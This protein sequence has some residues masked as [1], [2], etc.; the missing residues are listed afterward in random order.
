MNY[1]YAI[2]LKGRVM[3]FS[4]KNIIIRVARLYAKPHYLRVW[5]QDYLRDEITMQDIY[6]HHLVRFNTM[7]KR[8][9]YF[10]TNNEKFIP[11]DI[12]SKNARPNYQKY[13]KV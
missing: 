10:N 7:K 9:Q 1:C 13:W 4:H 5:I 12:L 3:L 11:Y 2:P 6:I 8:I